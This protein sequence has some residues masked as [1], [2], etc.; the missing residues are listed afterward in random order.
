MILLIDYPRIKK[1][2]LGTFSELLLA[3][4]IQIILQTTIKAINEQVIEKFFKKKFINL[5]KFI[6]IK[7]N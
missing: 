3:K 1:F 6:L 2:D 4:Y 7:Y 5:I